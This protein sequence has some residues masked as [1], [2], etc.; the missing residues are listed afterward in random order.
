MIRYPNVVIKSLSVN[1]D[2]RCIRVIEFLSS[3]A[4]K[5]ARKVRFCKPCTSA[6]SEGE[7]DYANRI[8]RLKAC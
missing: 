2:I 3:N 8:L 5:Y 4:P 6:A 7:F 1:F